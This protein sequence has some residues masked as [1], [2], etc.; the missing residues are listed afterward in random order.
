MPP[1][2][3]C[4]A[5][6]RPV[7]LGSEIARGGEGAVFEVNGQPDRVAKKYLKAQPAWV[8]QKLQAMAGMARPELLKV[9]AWPEATLHDG[10]GGSVIGLVMRKV[11]GFREIHN[12]YSPAARR[13]HYPQANW[14]FLLTAAY[15]CAA[16]L[17]AYHK[18]GVIAGDIAG[19]NL[20]VS[21]QA[22]VVFIDCDSCQVDSNGTIYKCPVGTGEFTPPELQDVTSFNGII[23]TTDHD[24]FGLAVLVFHLLFMGRHPFSG[25]YHGPGDMPIEKAIKEFRFA[26]GSRAVAYQ[27]AP[28]P[29]SLPFAVVPASVTGL[30]ERAFGPGSVNRGARAAASEWCSAL[31]GLLT[32]LK[33]CS[34]RPAHIYPASQSACPWC[35]L[36][37]QGGPDFFLTVG[38]GRPG[39]AGPG[40]VLIQVWSR[41]EQIAP[42]QFYYQR[43]NLPKCLPTPWPANLPR[44]APPA[45]AKPG[46]LSSTPTQPPS[47]VAIPGIQPVYVQRSK[48]QDGLGLAALSCLTGGALL[49]GLALFFLAVGAAKGGQA[50]SYAIP[51][52]MACLGFLIVAPGIATGIM[53]LLQE[54]KRLTQEELLNREYKVAMASYRRALAEER[55]QWQQRVAMQRERARREHNDRVQEW[56]RLTDAVNFEAQRRRR[57]HR[58]AEEALAYAEEQLRSASA[59]VARAFADA[60]AN[61]E[62]VRSRYR[63]IDAEYQ[64]DWLQLQARA[65]E[66]QLLQHLDGHLIENAKIDKIGVGRKA[67]LASFGIETALDVVRASILTVPGFGEG[68]AGNLLAWRRSVEAQFVFDTNRGVP[69]HEQQ[70]LVQK[71]QQKREPLERGLN[72]GAGRLQ[73]IVNEGDVEQMSLRGIIAQKMTP[74]GLAA[75]DLL[76]IP[77]GL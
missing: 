7:Q 32:E 49:F 35:Q 28:P 70:A 18:H 67:A 52:T 11:S 13:I 75:A 71:Y 36:I 33:S 29:H 21:D 17:E 51:T 61:L 34:V 72:A 3:V 63:S 24:L 4:D 38:A 53:W 15:N 22:Q 56:T 25:R 9:A 69:A 76:A 68:L 60:K 48:G 47:M 39:Q 50:R 10:P 44:S 5:H 6:N 2:H 65:S 41:I 59:R 37:Q 64:R 66:L 55:E 14:K 27:M 73:K 74:L 31:K 19:R 45:P 54:R 16:A 46:I 40:F 8:G 26:Y 57:L 77:A 58:Q 12:L 62:E 23:R 30:F 20:M 1:N 42:P 43:Q